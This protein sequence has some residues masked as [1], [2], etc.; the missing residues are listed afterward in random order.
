[1]ARQI[2]QICGYFIRKCQDEHRPFV[3]HPRRLQ[4][5]RQF[6]RGVC[7]AHDKNDCIRIG[8]SVDGHLRRPAVI[9]GPDAG[10]IR[11]VKFSGQ[12]PGARP[13]RRT[14]K[15]RFLPRFLAGKPAEQRRFAG[16][17]ETDQHR[18]A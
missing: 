14:A 7:G 2:R 17:L 6:H 9:L 10:K 13:D 5:Q 11:K 3:F 12:M 8:D 18:R 1:M 16:G 15:V 4:Q